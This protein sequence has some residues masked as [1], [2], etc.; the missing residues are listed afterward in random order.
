MSSSSKPVTA[1]SFWFAGG[2][3]CSGPNIPGNFNASSLQKLAALLAI[4]LLAL[5][6]VKKIATARRL[7]SKRIV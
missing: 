3:S 7:I 5:G 1:H 6:I 4:N 2:L